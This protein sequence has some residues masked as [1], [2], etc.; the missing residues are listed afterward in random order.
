MNIQDPQQFLNQ[1]FDAYN[2]RSDTLIKYHLDTNK[3]TD[4][5]II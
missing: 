3:S 4:F 5:K 1:Q 2:L